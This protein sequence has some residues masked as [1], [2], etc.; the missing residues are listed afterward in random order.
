M[1]PSTSIINSDNS[2]FLWFFLTKTID[3]LSIIHTTRTTCSSSRSKER[4]D[5]ATQGTHPLHYHRNLVWTK[6]LKTLPSNSGKCLCLIRIIYWHIAISSL[7]FLP[8]LPFQPWAPGYPRLLLLNLARRSMHVPPLPSHNKCFNPLWHTSHQFSLSLANT[9]IH[10]RISA[11]SWHL[12][13]KAQEFRATHCTI[14]SKHWTSGLNSRWQLTFQK[15][16][17]SLNLKP[18]IAFPAHY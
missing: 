2:L 16:T 12:T 17:H 11:H 9:K 10:T 6:T 13:S 14:P 1:P 15:S 18:H 7:N 8:D 5:H 4:K 3:R